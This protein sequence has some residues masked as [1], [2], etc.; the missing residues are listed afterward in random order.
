MSY[1]DNLITNP[2][3]ETGDTTGWT[4]TN[5]TVVGGTV[6]S[7]IFKP[8]IVD[9]GEWMEEVSPEIAHEGV[10]GTNYFNLANAYEEILVDSYTNAGNYNWRVHSANPS[11]GQ[12]FTAHTGGDLSSCIFKLIKEGTPTGTMVAKLY[13]HSGVYGVSSAPTGAALAT[14]ATIDV[15]T[16]SLTLQ[17][18]TFTFSGVNKYTLV[19]D[20][21]YI[22]ILEYSGGDS[23]NCVRMRVLW[24][25][26]AFDGIFVYYTDAWY[27]ETGQ[28]AYFYVY[29]DGTT[30]LPAT[31]TQTILAA[32][33]IPLP[34]FDF[35]IDLD[36]KLSVTQ[37]LED[38]TVKGWLEAEVLYS[39]ESV[40]LYIIPCVLGV[41][42]TER[43]L[44]NYWLR[45]TANILLREGLNLTSI[46]ITIKTLAS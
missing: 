8:T 29:C 41:M 4:A 40:D 30:L 38:A 6:D 31:M 10:D 1:G 28:D 37:D 23:L 35:K 18:T 32:D 12:A 46:K 24:D 27:V 14:S 26:P 11:V 3:A 42:T 2:D 36:F 15:S 9:A 13:A 20:T 19:K 7:V 21:Y 44:T 16:T 5:V 25:T 45:A 33:L 43:E 39:D 17:D 22:I 34:D